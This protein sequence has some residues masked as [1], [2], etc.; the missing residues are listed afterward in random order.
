MNILEVKNLRKV[1]RQKK[2]SA[3]VLE[4][5]KTELSL[6]VIAASRASAALAR[7]SSRGLSIS[8]SIPNHFSVLTRKSRQLSTSRKEMR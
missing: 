1:Y 5:Q 6:S 2:S 7:N 3:S 8:L 4:K